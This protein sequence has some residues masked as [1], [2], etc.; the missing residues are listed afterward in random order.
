MALARW[1]RH[2]RGAAVLAAGAAACIA[3]LAA[4]GGEDEAE[5]AY[6]VPPLR[7]E[8][9]HPCRSVP[10]PAEDALRSDQGAVR[11]PRPV[12]RRDQGGVRG[13]PA[14]G[15]R[16]AVARDD[17]RGRGRA[18]VRQL[19]DRSLLRQAVRL[20]AS[21]PRDGD[22]RHARHGTLWRPGLSRPPAGPGAG[23]DRAVQR[24]REGWDRCTGPT[25]PPPPPTTST[26]SAAPSASGASPCTGTPTGPSSPSPMPSGIRRRSRRWCSTRPIRRAARARGTRP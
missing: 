8:D 25:A 13:P 26:T 21:A 1:S 6:R 2:R 4:C 15:A 3:G 5:P 9:L 10:T 16:P 14:R 11:A 17:R 20:A 22:H 12:A 24:A 23:L 18:R 19:L 7:F